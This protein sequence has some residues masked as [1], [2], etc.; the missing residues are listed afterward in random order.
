[1]EHARKFVLLPEEQVSRHI[2]SKTQMSE[3]DKEMH[4]VLQSNLSDYEKVLQYYTLLQKK[5][6]IENFNLPWI[7][8]MPEAEEE[9]LEKKLNKGK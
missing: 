4:K 6:N 2:P 1:M 3:F 5:Q 7:K 9:A 8:Q